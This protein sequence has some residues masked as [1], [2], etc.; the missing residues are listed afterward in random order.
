VDRIA[1]GADSNI[2]IAALSVICGA[3]PA[4]FRFVVFLTG[5]SRF[6]TITPPSYVTF[7]VRGGVPTPRAFDYITILHTFRN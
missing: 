7:G 1:D 3:A 4:A 2:T 6:V 5:D